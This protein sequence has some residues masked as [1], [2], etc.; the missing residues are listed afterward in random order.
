MV[1]LRTASPTKVS[2]QTAL[3]SSSLVTSWPGCLT[4]WVSTAKALGL[5]LIACDPR[6]RHSF[7]RSRQKGSKVMN[8]SFPT[9]GHPQ[10]PLTCPASEEHNVYFAIERH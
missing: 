7:A 3:R 1:T 4:R 5:S 6:H 10:V 9:L 8:F 2:G